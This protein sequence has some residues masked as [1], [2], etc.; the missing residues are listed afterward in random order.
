M[1]NYRCYLQCGNDR[2]DLD[3]APYSTQGDF[4]PPVLAE[5]V[6][7]SSGTSANQY[8]GGRRSR[9]KSM[10]GE[11][12]IS[13]A[14]Q[15]GTSAQTE[16]SVNRLIR[17]L[18]RGTPQQPVYFCWVPANAAG[19]EPI[20]GTYG[21]SKRVEILSFSAEKNAVYY[22]V[23]SMRNRAILLD[24]DA[25]INPPKGW[26]VL[27]ARA[28]G[29]IFEDTIGVADGQSRGT[30]IPPAITNKFKNPIFAHLTWNTG[31]TANAGIVA[32][33]NIDK[34]F[35]LFGQ[36]SAKLYATVSES[37]YEVINVGNTNPHIISCY[38]R[39][40]DGGVI[41]ATIATL[42][43]N[44][45]QTTTFTPV[46]NG[47]YR[48]SASVTGV[49]ANQAV[50]IKINLARTLYV[51]GFQ[52]ETN[53][54]YITP[55][56]HADMLGC[57]PTGVL[58]ES[59][60]SRT[61]ARAYLPIG[62]DTF[63]ISQGSARFVVKYDVAN[64]FPDYIVYFDTRDAG[65]T[66]SLYLVYEATGDTLTFTDGVN[67]ATSAAQT[68]AVGDKVIYHVTWGPGGLF[69]YRNGV[70]IGTNATFTIP[71]AGVN[72]FIGSSYLTT[73][74]I[75]GTILGPAFFD[76]QLTGTEV[77]ADY[78]D[79]AAAV[80][81][82]Q[83]I[84]PIFWEWDKDGDSILDNGDSGSYQNW[85]VFGGIPGDLPA[86]TELYMIASGV[87]P[88]DDFYLS[89]LD[90]SIEDWLDPAF[91]IR[92][93]APDAV[94]V[95]TTAVSLA[96]FSLAR[97]QFRMIAG[98]QVIPIV[99]GDEDG[100]NN[101]SLQTKAGLA[102]ASMASEWL[103]ASFRSSGT[104]RSLDE[105][106]Q[107]GLHNWKDRF[108][109]L[110]PASYTLAVMAKRPT[111][112]A[113]FNMHSV[114]FLFLPFVRLTNTSGSGSTSPK[115]YYDGKAAYEIGV[116]SIADRYAIENGDQAI[117]LVPDRLNIL[118]VYAGKE[119]V[120]SSIAE[121]VTLSK[122]YVTPRWELA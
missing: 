36:A 114:H 10:P 79:L 19:V 32:A 77:L 70:Q 121:T 53:W 68:W 59:S 38:A 60:T 47:W 54:A 52:I 58:H 94:T 45:T 22:G 108:D 110:L 26:P 101:L 99:A 85:A 86:E 109:D 106:P 3:A 5:N 118:W 104:D 115:V 33:K 49:A 55:L 111:G 87:A 43:Y 75:P 48:L 31:W 27:A 37:F 6:A 11:Y 65:H 39:R 40:P 113:V 93:G 117:E 73:Y 102:S 112:S 15:G 72:V 25:V 29:G 18:R 56:A 14:V 4:A 81:D 88:D 44:T 34:N 84:D 91:L 105:A 120:L 30:V 24:I 23:G 61:A 62:T 95:G 51:D 92:N 96:T 7:I 98:R 74:Q 1:S 9:R 119:G 12:S 64:S 41:D 71:S 20:Y 122:V 46:G 67:S 83:R 78:N 28:V 50:G 97:L 89:L 2:L 8:G 82:E 17:F 69:L 66:T 103:A 100:A 116:V 90:V 13:V 57:A 80:A 63:Q 107:I 76:R 21:R 35:I 16:A 42:L